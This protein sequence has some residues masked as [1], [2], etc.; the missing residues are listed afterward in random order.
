MEAVEPVPGGDVDEVRGRRRPGRTAG[1][2]RRAARA[3]PS[4]DG[5]R[6]PGR[7]PLARRERAP[8]TLAAARAADRDAGTARPPM[9]SVTTA[10]VVA[11][12]VVDV[13][14]PPSP[15]PSR[16]R[17]RGSSG[18][19][20]APRRPRPWQTPPR[21]VGP[22]AR[23]PTAASAGRAGRGGDDA[24]GRRRPHRAAV[25]PSGARGRRRS[26]R[27]WRGPAGDHR[28]AA[29][30]PTRAPGASD[31]PGRRGQHVM[32]RRARHER[33]RPPVGGVSARRTGTP[34]GSRR[35]PSVPR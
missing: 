19:P 21:R 34:A 15:T 33:R 20:A 25:E 11:D 8:A 23:R 10:V 29:E 6:P 28:Q 1:P 12:R 9:R 2:G 31:R 30:R 5:A 13:D 22:D 35:R 18:R 27:R 26:G 24:A 16:R 14:C 3:S 4:G 17:A 7:R 32:A